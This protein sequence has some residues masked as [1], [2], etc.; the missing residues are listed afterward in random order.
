L[1]PTCLSLLL[2]PHAH[3]F[4]GWCCLVLSLVIADGSTT[5][6]RPR[7]DKAAS[8]PQQLRAKAEAFERGSR[9]SF[10]VQTGP[11]GRLQEVVMSHNNK[12][13]GPAW[14]LEA[15]EVSC[16]ATGEGGPHAWL[17]CMRGGGYP[18]KGGGM[19]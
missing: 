7:G 8:S 12:G 18:I 10:E 13:P 4:V 11:L 9:D 3:V 19:Q 5:P 1:M 14:Y 2:F 6:F 16:Q 17:G 15:V